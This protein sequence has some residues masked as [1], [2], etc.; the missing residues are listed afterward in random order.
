M[1]H[2]QQEYIIFLYLW[3]LF[4]KKLRNIVY[5]FS[6]KKMLQRNH[7]SKQLFA[8]S[9]LCQMYTKLGMLLS[10]ILNVQRFCC[11]SYP[12]RLEF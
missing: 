10:L 12:I 5:N 8:M 4:W 11:Y 2:V 9:I 3:K 7:K 1:F 6:L